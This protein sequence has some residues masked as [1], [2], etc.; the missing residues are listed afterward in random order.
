[1]ATND[2][3]AYFNNVHNT[4]YNK[5]QID[6]IYWLCDI[7]KM[8]TSDGISYAHNCHHCGNQ[9]ET[10][11]NEFCGPDCKL[12]YNFKDYNPEYRCFWDKECKMCN[13]AYKINDS[14]YNDYE[15]H[16][17]II[18]EEDEEIYDDLEY[19]DE[20]ED[21]DEESLPL[22]SLKHPESIQSN[23]Y[24]RPILERSSNYISSDED[25]LLLKPTKN[26]DNEAQTLLQG[27]NTNVFQENIIEMMIRIYGQPNKGKQ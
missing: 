17:D 24:S 4:S 21:E 9:I 22:L 3:V 6:G 2:N 13:K 27:E 12:M 14:N 15:L 10:I 18:E 25:D 7:Y 26:K 11:G 16:G 1:M 5:T 8:K 20:N 23:D 19:S